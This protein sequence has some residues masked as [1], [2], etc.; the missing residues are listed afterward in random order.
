[1]EKKRRISAVVAEK[2]SATA[3]AV[4]ACL[5]RRSYEVEAAST[6]QGLVNLL[7]KSP[8]HIAIIGDVEGSG[9]PF[10]T[11]REAVMTSPLTSVV[12]ITDA[13][14]HEVEEKA[15]GYGILGHVGRD[16]PKDVMRGLLDNFERIRQALT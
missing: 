8:V 9:S 14:A 4:A 1:M 2:D 3:A 12:L 11:L 13:P 15:E 5:S 10:E 6:R 7:K 16:M